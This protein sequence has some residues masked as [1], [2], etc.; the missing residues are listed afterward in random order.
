LEG[1]QDQSGRTG[2]LVGIP[3]QD[4]R[5]QG[6]QSARADRWVAGRLD[7]LVIHAATWHRISAQAGELGS[8][9]QPETV[10]IGHEGGERSSLSAKWR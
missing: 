6:E 5:L 9:S 1:I 2:Q 3:A 8:V 4:C 10:L 7:D